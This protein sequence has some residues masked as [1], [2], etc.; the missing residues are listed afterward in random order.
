MPTFGAATTNLPLLAAVADQ[1]QT[2]F[3]EQHSE[4]DSSVKKIA[5][6]AAIAFG[7]LAIPHIAD[8]KPKYKKELGLADC[9]ACHVK[10]DKEHDK[11]NDTNALWKT[12][13]DHAA[14]IKE[15]KG[16]FAGKKTCMD[17][18][19]GKSKP[20]KAADKK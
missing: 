10:G 7:L 9:D 8:A 20:E 4:R 14:K 18:H 3:N 6:A 15:A 19:N 2:N 13:K 17:C 11:A 12:A 5:L 16:D 1:K